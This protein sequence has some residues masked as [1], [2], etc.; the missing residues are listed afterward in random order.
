MSTLLWAGKPIVGCKGYKKMVLDIFYIIR[1]SFIMKQKDDTGSLSSAS[2]N[3]T[4]FTIWPL[5][6]GRERL[7]SVPGYL[8]IHEW[9]I[10]RKV[11]YQR[12]WPQ[13]CNTFHE[14]STKNSKDWLVEK[15]IYVEFSAEQNSFLAFEISE[16]LLV[17]DPRCSFSLHL[18][19]TG[20][21]FLPFG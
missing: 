12:H 7:T 6:I 16:R 1:R 3:L 11:L 9:P 20:C 21:N 15:S 13:H 4:C 8:A 10:L 18:I 2:G 14:G 17:A 19:A 5:T